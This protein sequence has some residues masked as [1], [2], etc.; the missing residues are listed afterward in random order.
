M[1]AKKCHMD[2]IGILLQAADNYSEPN[3]IENSADMFHDGADWIYCNK[4]HF[5][6]VKKKKMLMY[7]AYGIG[8]GSDMGIR[9][10]LARQFPMVEKWSS[11]DT[12]LLNS[13]KEIKPDLKI[14][15]YFNNGAPAGLA[16]DGANRISLNRHKM[17]DN[18]IPPFYPTRYK[19]FDCIPKE[20]IHLLNEYQKKD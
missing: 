19:L 1:M 12:W 2:S 13:L 18:P 3:R 6:H 9:T 5:Y 8:I 7:Y 16:T 20:I 10:E 17:F 15:E 14:V 11:V 4:I